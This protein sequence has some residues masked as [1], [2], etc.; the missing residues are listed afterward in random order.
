MVE[1]NDQVVKQREEEISHIVQSIGDLNTIFKDLSMLIIDQVEFLYIH[2]KY[3]LFYLE[4]NFCCL[5]NNLF[6]N[7]LSWSTWKM[8]LEI[9]LFS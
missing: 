8:A 6:L 4:L 3:S 2:F 1:E 5:R 7:S 9:D